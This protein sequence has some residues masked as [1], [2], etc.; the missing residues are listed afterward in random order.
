MTFLTARNSLRTNTAESIAQLTGGEFFH[1]HN[2]KDLK[3]DLITVLQRRA[4]LL[5]AHFSA[6]SVTPGLHALHMKIKDRPSWCSSL[7]VSIGLK[8]TQDSKA[9][10]TREARKGNAGPSTALRSGRDDNSVEGV[11]Y[12]PLKL[13]RQNRI[14]IP[15]GA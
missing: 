5:C 6:D 11:E 2:A 13:L 12:F 7:E 8:T 10:L 15:T 3:S 4:Q 1:F 9:Y 14:V